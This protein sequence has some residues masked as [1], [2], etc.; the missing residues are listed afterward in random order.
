MGY[1]C[2]ETSKDEARVERY[3][4]LDTTLTE[5][6]TKFHPTEAGV[7][8]LFFSKNQTTAIP[9]AEARGVILSALLRHQVEVFE[10]NPVTIKQAV[11]GSGRADKAAVEKMVR[12]QLQLPPVQGRKRDL[13]DALDALAVLVTHAASR[14]LAKRV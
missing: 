7:E 12:L 10:Y 3:R 9:V 2:I 13:D 4:Q 5:I 1:G 11:T 14:S 8:S 6:L